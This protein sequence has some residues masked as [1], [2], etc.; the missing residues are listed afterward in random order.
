ML[1]ALALAILAGACWCLIGIVFSQAADRG[2]HPA[3]MSAVSGLGVAVVTATWIDGS[4]FGGPDQDVVIVSMVIAGLAMTLG[5]VAVQRAMTLG[6]HGAAWAVAQAGVA[7]PFLVA[8]VIHGER[9]GWAPWIG[10]AAIVVSLALLAG[11]RTGEPAASGRWFPW[12]VLAWALIGLQQAAFQWPSWRGVD[13]DP[14]GLRVPLMCAVSG[15][16]AVVLLAVMPQDRS[17]AERLPW[18]WVAGLAILACAANVAAQ[19]AMVRSGDL[20]AGLGAGGLA[21]PVAIATC[22]ALFAVY[23]I[24]Q[25]GERPAPRT[26]LGLT[27]CL[28]GVVLMNL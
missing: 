4:K 9:P 28:M 26:W 5:M 20:L 7:W 2:L 1:T 10:L 11:R 12:A 17:V 3:L 21:F 22:I 6:G 19:P 8:V 18:R 27:C 14:A 24:I 15:L 16:G 13:P 23:A 25:R